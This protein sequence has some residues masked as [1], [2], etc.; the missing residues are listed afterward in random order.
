METVRA[1]CP[2]DCPDACGLLVDVEDGRA[3]KVRGDPDHPYS[4]GTLCPKVNGYER[5]VHH[6]GRL[7]RPS[8]GSP[9][10]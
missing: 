7:L 1:T 9:P 5:S 8:R 2:F 3:L 6:P 10:P 4:Q